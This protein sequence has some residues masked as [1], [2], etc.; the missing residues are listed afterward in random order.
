[1]RRFINSRC[2]GSSRAEWEKVGIKKIQFDVNYK[3]TENTKPRSITAKR[4]VTNDIFIAPWV[5]DVQ[6]V[7]VTSYSKKVR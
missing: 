5:G 2:Y 4:V 3:K 6:K 1:M 7:L